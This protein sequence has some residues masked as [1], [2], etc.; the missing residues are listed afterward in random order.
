MP[1]NPAKTSIQPARF[2][3]SGLLLVGC[4]LIL[5]NQFR[6]VI[7]VGDSMQPSLG[8]GD[9]LIANKREYRARDPERGELVV[10]WRQG[11][12]IVKRVVGIPGEEVEVIEGSLFV[13]GLPV[14][15]GY[16]PEGDRLSV[17]GGRLAP[18]RFALLGDNRGLVEGQTV[19]AIVS[20]EEI[21]GMVVAI[22]RLRGSKDS[23]EPTMA[24][25]QRWSHSHSDWGAGRTGTW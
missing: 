4:L 11:E 14:V 6:L 18:G 8:H 17:R 3:L 25:S 13:N 10:A 15:E 24:A 21:V 7:V 23:A 22:W 5:Q 2:C 12:F 1:A 9:L 16:G 19:H 20:K